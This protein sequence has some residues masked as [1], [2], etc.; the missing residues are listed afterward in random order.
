VGKRYLLLGVTP[1]R[2][3]CLAEISSEE[4][5]AT[6]PAGVGMADFAGLL[7]KSK[8]RLMSLGRTADSREE[9]EE[10]VG[11]RDES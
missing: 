7:Q 2:V 3:D 4:L 6:E 10:E 11:S 5:A 9:Q 8:E 1:T